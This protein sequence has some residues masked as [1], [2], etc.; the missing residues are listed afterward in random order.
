MGEDMRER[1]KQRYAGAA[2]TVLEGTGWP[3]VAGRRAS[4][5]WTPKR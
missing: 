5:A 2:L 4:G 1:V 3:R